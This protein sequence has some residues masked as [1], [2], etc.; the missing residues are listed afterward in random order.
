MAER[1]VPAMYMLWRGHSPRAIPPIPLAYSISSIVS[2]D[3]DKARPVIEMD[4]ELSD[5]A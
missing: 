5:S 2:E 3:M 1:S 4:G